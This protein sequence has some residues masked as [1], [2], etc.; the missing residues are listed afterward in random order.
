[1]SF[2]HLVRFLAFSIIG[3]RSMSLQ[4]P[5]AP[6]AGNERPADRDTVT[7][8]QCGRQVEVFVALSNQE[9]H[10]CL[11]CHNKVA[12]ADESET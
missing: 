1:M 7:C 5:A 10:L 3:P 12:A 4:E 2:L 11:L 6:A 9:E 8:D